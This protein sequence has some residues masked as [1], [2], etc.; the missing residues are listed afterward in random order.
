M[1]PLARYVEPV[2][3]E[4]EGVRYVNLRDPLHFSD[5]A[6]S[7][8]FPAYILMTMMDGEKTLDKI[9]ADFNSNFNASISLD[10]LQGLL[11]QLD[12]HFL[13]VNEN[14]ME[15][16]Q[17]FTDDFAAIPV[18]QAALAGQS[19]PKDPQE[20]STLLDGYLERTP[21]KDTAPFAI[22]APHI[23]LRV[24]GESF[25][26]AFSSLRQ[27]TAGTFVILAIGHTLDGDFFACIDKDFETPLGTSPVDREF[28]SGLEADFGEPIYRHMY[29]HKDEHSAEFQVLFLQKIFQGQPPRKI[30]PILL[31]FPE[32]IEEVQHPQYNIARVRKFVEALR[33]GIQKL[34]GGA[35]L[36]AGVDL[37]HVGRRFGQEDGVDKE[38]LAEVETDDRKLL[39]LVGEG[40]K[41]EFVNFMKKKNR[42]NNICGYPALY[43]LIDLLEGRN[44]ELL[45]Y[46]Q[47]VEGE[48]DSMVSFAS[49]VFK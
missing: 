25:G 48:N 8:S 15:K 13:L 38:R 24:G 19:Y 39:K 35:C 42:A 4:H 2:A 44:G 30:V 32:I 6:L 47:S 14:F 41:K 28:L 45:D 31:S 33:K 16:R 23:D 12:K 46:R 1:K 22:I 36:I 11:T 43:V 18:R 27:S 26:A 9:C 20:L 5:S 49:M 37:S 3:F 29:A 40:K 10:D 17:R 7:V 21:P 34:N